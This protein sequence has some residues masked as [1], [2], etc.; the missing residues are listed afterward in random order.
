MTTKS[1]RKTVRK[2]F[3]LKLLLLKARRAPKVFTARWRASPDFIIVGTQKGGTSS[4]YSYIIQHPQ[5]RPATAPYLAGEVNYFNASYHRG[6]SW[7]RSHFPLVLFS[8]DRKWITGEKSPNYMTNP[9]VFDRIYKF[10]PN[11][12]LIVLLRNPVERAI[13]HYCMMRKVGVETISIGDALEQEEERIGSDYSSLTYRSYSYQ[14]RG[15]YV[16]QM[17]RCFKRFPRDQVM[18][19]KSEDLFTKPYEILKD[20]FVYLGVDQNYRPPDI[21][22][23]NA[24]S[25]NRSE[26]SAAYKKLLDYYAPHNKRLYDLLNR[27]FGW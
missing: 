18:I 23:K 26:F 6:P 10:S 13:S 11:I 21:C 17:E 16:E 15:I 7:Y 27:D 9:D 4:L 19:I 22:P 12:K 1:L 25:Y 2:L 20:V 8:K 14:K 24:G 3:P 5:I